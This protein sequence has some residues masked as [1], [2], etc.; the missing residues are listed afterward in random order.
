MSEEIKASGSVTASGEPTAGETVTSVETAAATQNATASDPVNA[1][2]TAQSQSSVQPQSPAAEN[3]WMACLAY[4]PALFFVP[5]LTGDAQKNEVTRNSVNQ[6]LMCLIMLV[7]INLL[8]RL[9][10]LLPYRV[11]R[12]FDILITPLSLAVLAFVIVGMVQG[13]KNKIFKLP[14]IGD[15]DL[16]QKIKSKT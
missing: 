14:L 12:I 5:I 9:F 2:P 3:N 11:S 7:C 1:N 10:S 16:I 13:Y 4:C 6:G 8:N 15:I